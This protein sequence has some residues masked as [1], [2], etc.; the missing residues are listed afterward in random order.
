MAQDRMKVGVV[1][2]S[3]GLGKDWQQAVAKVA[4]M[5]AEGVQIW[6]TGYELG[7][8]L[9][10]AQADEVRREIERQGLT[11][12]AT[13][14]EVGGFAEKEHWQQ[15]VELT[16]QFLRVTARLGAKVMTGH[17]GVIPADE[18]HPAWK[19]IYEAL[20]TIARTCE[21]TGV[22]YAAETGPEHPLVLRRM[23]EKVGSPYLGV[24]YDPANLVM[25]GYSPEAGLMVLREFVFHTHAKDGRQLGPN[26]AQEVPLGQGDVCFPL[27]LRRLQ[28]IGYGG[29]LA[30][31]REGGTDR[32]GDVTRAIEFL[33][34][35][36][37]SLRTAAAN[38]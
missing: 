33:R 3:L 21:E 14:G 36:L 25:Q 32:I 19:N 37:G 2:T 38:A 26:Q 1:T 31:E 4:Q 16:K 6:V 10:Q 17:I 9:D 22:R 5:G 20:G 8:E 23:L 12:S 30:I 7:P 34:K 18:S 11:L 15:R 13:C 27:Y 24:N 35:S 29:F 28:E